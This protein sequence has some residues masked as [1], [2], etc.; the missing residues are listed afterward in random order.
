MPAYFFSLCFPSV[1]WPTPILNLNFSLLVLRVCI[2]WQ[3]EETCTSNTSIFTHISIFYSVNLR[4][5][6]ALKVSLWPFLCILE[7]MMISSPSLMKWINGR[8]WG[9]GTGTSGHLGDEIANWHWRPLL[10]ISARTG[11]STRARQETSSQS[12]G[13]TSSDD[14][15]PRMGGAPAAIPS[16]STRKRSHGKGADEDPCTGINTTIKGSAPEDPLLV[17]TPCPFIYLSLC[18]FISL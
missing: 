12:S 5:R 8:A 17:P 3:T 2:Q 18:S 6:C 11:D 1:S 14:S 13:R 10:P 4:P 16:S 7:L 9:R 15:H